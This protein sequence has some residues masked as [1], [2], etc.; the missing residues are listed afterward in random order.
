MKANTEK[1]ENTQATREL[2]ARLIRRYADETGIK[3]MENYVGR[4]SYG[5]TCI[6][7][8][9]DGSRSLI[10]DLGEFIVRVL[11]EGDEQYNINELSFEFLG[12]YRV[13]DMGLDEVIYW[14]K[15]K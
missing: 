3:L 13:D 7:L 9:T 2:L 14:P 4:R 6:A 11:D 1:M 8:V 5:E 10:A 12:W 15:L